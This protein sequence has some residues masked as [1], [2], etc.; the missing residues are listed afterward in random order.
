MSDAPYVAMKT[1]APLVGAPITTTQAKKMGVADA[2]L[3][4]VTGRGGEAKKFKDITVE[5][6]LRPARRRR[7]RGW[8]RAER[9]LPP[10][11][12]RGE[13]DPDARAAGQGA[14]RAGGLE[15]THILDE[16]VI[17]YL[18]TLDGNTFRIIFR[19]TSGSEET[20]EHPPSVR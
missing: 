11:D 10:A 17:S 4:T 15:T 13:A 1:G 18:M 8:H 12:G 19:D 16:G 3:I 9:R 7:R 5:P 2:Q 20:P 14:R 6:M